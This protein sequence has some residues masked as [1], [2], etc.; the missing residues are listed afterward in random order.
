MSP[1]IGAVLG[2]VAVGTEGNG[3]RGAFSG[4]GAP[5][6]LFQGHIVSSKLW[7]ISVAGTEL[8]EPRKKNVFACV[9][10]KRLLNHCQRAHSRSTLQCRRKNR[11][12]R[13]AVPGVR[14]HSVKLVCAN[15]CGSPSIS[16]NPSWSVPVSKIA[17]G[18]SPPLDS[19]VA[20]SLPKA[21][22]SCTSNRPRQR[23]REAVSFGGVE[24]VRVLANA[25]HH[26]LGHQR[27]R[28]TCLG[29]PDDGVPIGAAR[30]P[31]DTGD[32]EIDWRAVGRKHQI[33]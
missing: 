9:P 5:V 24:L 32:P 29:H 28:H 10:S 1:T 30:L 22:A 18:G 23:R 19:V 27:R 8:A 16:S 6:T 17:F 33:Q 13:G 12:S 4:R 21:P 25:D 20:S 14:I 31:H 15:P 7:P 26:R 2:A 11:G 3:V